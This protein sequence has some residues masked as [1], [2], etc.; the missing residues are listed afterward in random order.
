[1]EGKREDIENHRYLSQAAPA[2]ILASCDAIEARTQIKI[3]WANDASGAA[4]RLECLVWQYVKGIVRDYE[5]L[6]SV[7]PA[8]DSGEGVAKA[9]EA[10]ERARREPGGHVHPIGEVVGEV[11]GAIT[12]A[13]GDG[14]EDVRNSMEV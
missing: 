6:R 4:Q 10:T 1:I 9:P 11:L 5:T 14:S 7:C 13:R 12:A 8:E 2:A 3:L